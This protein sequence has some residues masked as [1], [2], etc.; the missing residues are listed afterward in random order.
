MSKVIK[1]SEDFRRECHEALDKELD[2]MKPGDDK[3]CFSKGL[4]KDTRR[5]T[6]WFT[7]MAWQKMAALLSKFSAEVAWHGVA[8]RLEGKPCE[9]VIEDI[10]V[11]PQAVSGVMVDMD[12]ERYAEWKFQ[13]D[14]E[15]IVNMCMQG[16]SHV[17]MSTSPSSTDLA[18]QREIVNGLK[19]DGFYIFQIWNKMLESTSKIY[20]LKEDALF[21]DE[22]I[23]VRIQGEYDDIDAFIKAAKDIVVDYKPPVKYPSYSSGANAYQYQGANKTAEAKTDKKSEAKTDKKAEVKA[24]KKAEVK[25]GGGIPI[26]ADD[27]YGFGFDAYNEGGWR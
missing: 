3:L 6:V 13:C 25:S 2:S 10:L 19:N 9:Y 4:G 7:L 27:W 15:Q 26:H 22:D 12:P 21:E 17:K 11:Y 20:D 8:K 24:D 5:A 14:D 18:H 1:L 23:D 16:H